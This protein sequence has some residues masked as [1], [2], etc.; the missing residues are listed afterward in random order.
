MKAFNKKKKPKHS[1]SKIF[2]DYDIEDNEKTYIVFTMSS[3]AQS[4]QIYSLA[5]D[6]FTPEKRRCRRY[7]GWVEMLVISIR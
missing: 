5:D 1:I 3:K 4:N 6:N 7:D 2:Y